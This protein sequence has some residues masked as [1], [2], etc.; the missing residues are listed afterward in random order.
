MVSSDELTEIKVQIAEMNG[1]MDSVVTVV[2]DLK[3][4]VTDLKDCHDE[5]K[6]SINE[7]KLDLAGRPSA[8]ELKTTISDVKTFKT[9]FVLIGSAVGIAIAWLSNVSAKL[10]LGR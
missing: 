2:N 4:S 10:F 7:I 8:E 9:Y 1:K 3:D 6:D 5:M